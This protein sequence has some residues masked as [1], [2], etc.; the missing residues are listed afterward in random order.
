[1]ITLRGVIDENDLRYVQTRFGEPLIGIPAPGEGINPHISRFLVGG[2]TI[3][4]FHVKPVYYATPTGEWRP[5]YEVASYYGNRRGLVLKEGWENKI[6]FG[7][8]VWYQ[9]RLSLIKGR[10]IRFTVQQGAHIKPLEQPVILNTTSTFYPDPD[11]E[12]TSVDGYEANSNADWATAHDAATGNDGSDSLTIADT[13]S[14]NDGVEYVIRRGFTLFDTSAITDTDTI[15]SATYSLYVTTKT[16][17]DNDAQAYITVITTSPAS[18]TALTTADYDQVGTTEQNA[19]GA[20]LD[21]T[22]ITTSAYNDIA[23]NATG[24]GNISKTGV[25]KFG[26]REGHD[27]ENSA[28]AGSANSTIRWSTAEATS[29]TQDPKLVVVHSAAAVTG[30]MTT[31]SKFW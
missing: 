27:L 14:Q 8:L 25:T 26:T 7:Y 3:D 17:G 18:N 28:V 10:G 4:I 5:F 31:N 24:L 6:D 16:D 15:D 30:F 22:N 9:R 13:R 19:S 12:S 20:R 21:I 1:M 2:K 29:T 23:L 11:P